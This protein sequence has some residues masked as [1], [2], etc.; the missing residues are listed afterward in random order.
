M[1][2]MLFISGFS[3]I[4]GV[5]YPVLAVLF[6]RLSGNQEPIREILKRL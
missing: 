1:T 3:L 2:F 6:A 5:V 4:L